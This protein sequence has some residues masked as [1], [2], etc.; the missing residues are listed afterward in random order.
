MGWGGGYKCHLWTPAP[1]DCHCPPA[2]DA[3]KRSLPVARCLLITRQTCDVTRVVGVIGT[4]V[5]RLN[6][7]VT[8]RAGGGGDRQYQLKIRGL[9]YPQGGDRWVGRRHSPRLSTD[10]IATHEPVIQRCN[11]PYSCTCIYIGLHVGPI[12]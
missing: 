5:G 3:V 8:T 9:H 1:C 11:S 12:Q 7:M 10:G 4:R 6:T 2:G